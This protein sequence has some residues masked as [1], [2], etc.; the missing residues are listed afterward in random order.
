MVKRFEL[1]LTWPETSTRAIVPVL[2]R[3]AILHCNSVEHL[4]SIH[5]FF[6]KLYNLNMVLIAGLLC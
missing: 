2:L 4:V 5:S 1:G 6:K 3:D